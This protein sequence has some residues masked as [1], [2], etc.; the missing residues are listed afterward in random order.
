LGYIPCLADNDVWYRANVRETDGFEYYEYVL[1]YVDDILCVSHAA[2]EALKRINKFFPMKPGSIQAPD[3]YLGAKISKVRLPNQ[4][5]AWAMSP[6]KYIQE[7][8]SNVEDYLTREYC[9][10]KLTHKVVTPFKSGY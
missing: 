6:S 3:I 1:I 9:G 8:V 5:E 4:V 7:A 2:K 10:R